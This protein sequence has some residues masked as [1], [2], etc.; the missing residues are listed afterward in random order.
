M[1][2]NS[3]ILILLLRTWT[4]DIGGIYDYSTK[5]VKVITDYVKESTY[6]V[7]D[8]NNSFKNIS[9]HSNIS[10]GDELIFHVLCDIDNIIK[11]INPIPRN[12]KLTNDNCVYLNNKI[13][14]VIKSENSSEIENN[15]E[16]Y[17]LLEGDIIKFGKIK[18]AVQKIH[19]ENNNNGIDPPMAINDLM[20]YDI[21][22]LNENT[23]PAFNYIF[24]VTH[25]KN[26]G[27]NNNLNDSSS[28]DN[29][30]KDQKEI[31]CICQQETMQ[32]QQQIELE[33]DDGESNSLISLCKCKGK[34][35]AH[36]G[37]L[38][39]SFIV[40]VENK[41]D[42]NKLDTNII[43]E[44][45]ECRTCGEQYPLKFKIGNES[46]PRCLI[47]EYKEPE[48]GNFIILESLDFKKNEKY[49]KS[50][51]IVKL[52]KDSISIGREYDNDIVES[53]ISI[54]RSH[55][56]LKF[57]RINNKIC[58][59]NRSKKFGTL[60]LVKKPIKILDKKIHLQVGRTYIEANLDDKKN[61]ENDN[62][63]K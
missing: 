46:E 32:Q 43:I 54:S 41:D 12:L 53:D 39:N 29:N 8:K 47:K 40:R 58:L 56:V 52:N 5:A 45:F 23:R 61:H 17:F 31:C 27:E 57:N 62:L 44:N 18:F 6:V 22:K 55:A 7:R 20:K 49:C 33:T 48:E 11:L 4:N 34:G 30:E 35:L 59:Q 10:S 37:C 63:D 60:V 13:W 36:I 1:I 38:K 42:K 26:I 19:T 15:N 25:S 9:Q 28:S 16:D 14:Y 50:I 21:S 3:K 24:N 51:H 2:E